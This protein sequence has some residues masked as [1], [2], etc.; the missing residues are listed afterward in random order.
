MHAGVGFHPYYEINYGV[1]QI[2]LLMNVNV[3]AGF[4]KGMLKTSGIRI[5][6]PI[7][8]GMIAL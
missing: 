4:E 2:F 1:H 3:F 7:R 5:G 8:G 6:V